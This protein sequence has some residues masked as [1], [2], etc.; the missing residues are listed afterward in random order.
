MGRAARAEQPQRL[1]GR[2][3]NDRAPQLP[4]PPSFNWQRETLDAF[5]RRL[6]DYRETMKA[7]PGIVETPVKRTGNLHF[8]WLAY[9]HVDG[10]TQARISEKY[11]DENGSPSVPAVSL[12]ITETA[13]LAHITLRPMRGRGK[14]R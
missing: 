14:F 7:M 11:Q 5:K 4:P 9:H 2:S 12:A 6:D 8:E 13:A 3:R 10:W 1:A